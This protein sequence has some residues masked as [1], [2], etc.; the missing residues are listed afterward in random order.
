MLRRRPG[1]QPEVAPAADG[2]S[3]IDI[4]LDLFVTWDLEDHTAALNG[5]GLQ[6]G[7]SEGPSDGLAG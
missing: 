4:T 7:R 2:A 1:L 6:C 5:G 3:P